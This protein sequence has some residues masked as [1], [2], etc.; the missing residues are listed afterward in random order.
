MTRALL[1]SVL[2]VSLPL[3]LSL[4]EPHS[5]ADTVLSPTEFLPLRD[6]PNRSFIFSN[7]QSDTYGT[8]VHLVNTTRGNLTFQWVDLVFN[9]D[10]VNE[11]LSH[12][13][14]LQACMSMSIQPP[15]QGP[16]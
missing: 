15:G 14:R 1:L 12:D 10:T 6:R 16:K 8:R 11:A 13:R 7:D 9:G 4:N 5:S 3:N 2:V